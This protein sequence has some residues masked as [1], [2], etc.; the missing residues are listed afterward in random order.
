M[1]DDRT[2]NPHFDKEQAE[3]ERPTVDDAIESMDGDDSRQRPLG[4]SHRPAAEEDRQPEKLPATR[5]AN[6]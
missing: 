1:P 5:A 2:P 6:E 3:G 4:I